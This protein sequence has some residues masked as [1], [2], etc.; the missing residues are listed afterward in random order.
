MDAGD[1]VGADEVAGLVAPLYAGVY[2]MTTVMDMLTGLP[3]DIEKFINIV[4]DFIHN[5]AVGMLELTCQLDGA[6]LSA[7]CVLVY[8][9]SA[10]P[11]PDGMTEAGE[12]I[13]QVLSDHVM[14]LGDNGA[15]FMGCGTDFNYTLKHM[16]IHQTLTIDAEPDAMG[17]LDHSNVQVEWTGLS[18]PIDIGMCCDVS[19]P[20]CMLDVNLTLTDVGQELLVGHF[21][22]QV[23]GYQN[24]E[25]DKF[26][27]MPYSVNFKYGAFMN[28]VMEKMVLPQVAG[29]GTDGLPAV[30]S[31][32]KLLKAILGGKSCLETDDCCEKFVAAVLAKSSELPEDVL[33]AGCQ[34]ILDSEPAYFQ[35]M[36]NGLN[37][38]NGEG[39][40]LSTPD[41]QACALFDDNSDDVIDAWGRSQ[42]ETERCLWTAKLGVGSH[43]FLM[44]A[45]FWATRLP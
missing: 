30:D 3:D 44:N 33:A 31:Y 19:N 14:T 4:I 6:A 13:L 35:G 27:I 10:D 37:P 26:R 45:E 5:P 20:D 29:D 25:F 17:F 34:D 23:E 18:L 1:E 32:V 12:A 24:G 38:T 2:E 40:T 21:D 7:L 36:L 41:D 11:S 22:G 9:D 16:A 28:F 15:Y 39:L 43:I 42:P 8:D